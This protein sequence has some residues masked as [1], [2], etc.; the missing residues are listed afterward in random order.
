MSKDNTYSHLQIKEILLSVFIGVTKEE[1]LKVSDLT[2]DIII[3]FK[4]MPQ[5]CLS[6]QL[7][8]SVCYQKLTDDLK[9]F[10]TDKRF[11]VIEYFGYQ[12]YEFI[13][14]KL[15][16]YCELWLAVTKKPP[17]VNFNKSIFCIGD[18]DRS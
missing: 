13:K 9:D 14:S 5:A 4:E 1:Q 8:D 7:E 15:P 18:W 16:E 3:R 17:C 2:V 10:C 11:G 6:D 12:L